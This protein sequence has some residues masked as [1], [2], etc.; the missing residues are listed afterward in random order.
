MTAEKLF[1]PVEVLC[2][3]SIRI[4]GSRTVYFDPFRVEGQP[5]D[6]DLILIT[7]DHFDHFSPDD[8]Q[9][10]R[11]A[12][13]V[14]VTPASTAKEAAGLGF[15][16]HHTMAPGDRLEIA[17]VTI[18]TVASYNTNKPNHPKEN[19]W[20]GY[21]L[22]MDGVRYYVAGDTDDIPEARAVDCDLA[23]VP[24]GGTYTMTAA[25][26]ARMVNAMAPKAAVPTHYAAIVGTKKD[27]GIFLA[28]LDKSILCQENIC[29]GGFHQ[30]DEIPPIN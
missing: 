3:S 24:V 10:V 26:A 20:L 2:H 25:E 19:G 12:Q 4:T 9:K 13:T 15:P 14:L 8:I 27:A 18:E 7:H 5:E 11:G 22:T 28:G 16:E 23:L 6:A 17:G 21:I 30:K 1:D 29:Q